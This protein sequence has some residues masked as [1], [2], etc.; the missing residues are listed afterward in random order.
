VSESPSTATINQGKAEPNP[1]ITSAGT[2]RFPPSVGDAIAG[3]TVRYYAAPQYAPAPVHVAQAPNL[4]P[5]PPSRFNALARFMK[6]LFFFLLVAGLVGATAGAVFFSQEASRERR[7]RNELEQRAEARADANGRAKNAWEQME[8]AVKL[9]LEAEEKAAGA[10]ATLSTGAE[11]PVD[12]GKYAYPGAQ[13]EAKIGNY[14][15]ETLS[16]LTPNNFA[17]VREFYERQF[18]KPVIQVL[19][20]RHWGQARKKILFQSFPILVRVEEIEKSQVKITIL[21]SLLRFPKIDEAQAQ[22]SR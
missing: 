2:G 19:D 8:D 5:P 20:D 16:M 17:T 4:A 11:K 13:S 21:H 22:N 3:E 9:I 6:G 18:G 1:T 10:G 12:L 14:G 15:S 7:R